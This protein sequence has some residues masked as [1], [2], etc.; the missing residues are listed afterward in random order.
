MR[1]KTEILKLTLDQ[2]TQIACNT[3]Q[4]HNQRISEL[5][6]QVNG[7][8]K[9]IE[10]LEG[11]IKSVILPAITELENNQVDKPTEPVGERVVYRNN[12]MRKEILHELLE[13]A[14]SIMS[15]WSRRLL[16]SVYNNTT[17]TEKQFKV[18]DE[19]VNTNSPK[20]ISKWK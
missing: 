13:D 12:R 7:L 6:D 11:R 4:Q 19:I 18:L 20:N 8:K 10:D 16:A 15:N 9:Y 1:P 5:E 14:D 2:V 3:R 17:W